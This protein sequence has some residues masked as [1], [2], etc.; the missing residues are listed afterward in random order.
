MKLKRIAPIAV[1][2]II[3]TNGI[4]IPMIANAEQNEMND[5]SIVEEE[6]S[7]TFRGI[8]DIET[9]VE[10]LEYLN[11]I[12]NNDEITQY[13]DMVSY[14]NAMIDRL[15]KIDLGDE[16]TKADV[17]A[18]KK[19]AK[20]IV[21]YKSQ[22]SAR[23]L[24][25]VKY[26]KVEEVEEKIAKAAMRFGIKDDAFLVSVDVDNA[27]PKIGD[28]IKMTAIFPEDIVS[29]PSYQWQVKVNTRAVEK[30]YGYD[31][32][33]DKNVIYRYGMDES[34]EY[35]FPFEDI[36]EGELLEINPN[37][38]WPGIELYLAI[39]KTLDGHGFDSTNL[40]IQPTTPNYVLQGYDVKTADIV[41]DGETVLILSNGNGDKI[42]LYMDKDGYIPRVEAPNSEGEWVD[43]DGATDRELNVDVNRETA[44][45]K[46]RVI[47]NGESDGLLVSGRSNEKE[48]I[49]TRDYTTKNKNE[50]ATGGFLKFVIIVIA[51]VVAF[52]GSF[53]GTTMSRKYV[54]DKAVIQ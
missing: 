12:V 35:G 26:N 10:S 21:E 6:T 32:K 49:I 36:T 47:V 14:V 19:L 34:T 27:M 8:N 52:I 23:E 39:K 2:A 33:D 11:S 38:T 29:E 45:S 53:I 31:L 43:I 20:Q 15:L 5:A 54:K 1:A 13:N 44:Y 46:Y 25:F 50:K 48:M 40:H 4:T 9:D 37:G 24:P 51:S 17:I 41:S 3:L 42:N 22:L 30:Q 18:A 16:C 28:T 7:D